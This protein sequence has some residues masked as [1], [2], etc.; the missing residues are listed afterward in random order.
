M[1]ARFESPTI[2]V[3]F[4]TS[5]DQS[6]AFLWVWGCLCGS[7]R[8]GEPGG[9]VEPL[10]G[11]EVDKSGVGGEVSLSLFVVPFI[12]MDLLSTSALAFVLAGSTA[13]GTG[14]LCCWGVISVVGEDEIVLLH[15]RAT[16]LCRCVSEGEGGDGGEGE[17]EGGPDGPMEGPACEDRRRC[18]CL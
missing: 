18:S 17:E 8:P 3:V 4:R 10:L 5:S 12:I 11:F 15:G 16:L 2:R 13:R 7:S 1:R 9:A 6:C 14:S